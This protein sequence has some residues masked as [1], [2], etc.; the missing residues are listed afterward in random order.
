MPATLDVGIP[1]PK[2]S[3]LKLSNYSLNYSA[4]IDRREMDVFGFLGLCRG[5][6]LE[7]AS[8]HL[9]DLPDTRLETLARVRRA[10]L[11]QG[12]SVAMATVSTEFGQPPDRLGAEL[13]RARMAIH[14]AAFFGGPI[15]QGF[16]WPRFP[17]RSSCGMGKAVSIIKVTAA[18]GLSRNEASRSTRLPPSTSFMLK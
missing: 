13:D 10:Y 6:G 1:R 2:E 15:A 5:L 14:A 3:R 9:R 11:D 4:L 16:R 12:L 8:L 17:N 18:R 7:G